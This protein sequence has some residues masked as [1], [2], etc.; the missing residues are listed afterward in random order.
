MADIKRKAE[1]TWTGDLKS[2]TG[3]TSGESGAFKDVECTFATRFGDEKGSNPEELIGAAH[4]SCFSMQLSGLLGRDGHEPKSIHTEAT[5]T[6]QKTEGGFKVS[7]VHLSTQGDVPGIDEETFQK[8]AQEA[9]ETCPISMLLM[10][11]LDEM[12]L[13]A[14]LA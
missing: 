6:L 7:S 12:T 11:G 14:T 1:A 4:S 3:K 9:K 5:V 2:G 10:P 8:I 13:D